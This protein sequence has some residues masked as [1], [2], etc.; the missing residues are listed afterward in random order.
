MLQKGERRQKGDTGST[1]ALYSDCDSR[2]NVAFCKRD[3]V[4]M[5]LR[6]MTMVTGMDL[7]EK[8]VMVHRAMPANLRPGEADHFQRLATCSTPDI[9]VTEYCDAVIAEG[10]EP[11][12]AGQLLPQYFSEEHRFLERDRERFVRRGQRAEA[13]AVALGGE[14]VF[15]CDRFSANY[16]HWLCDALPRLEAFSRRMAEFS[17]L[18]PPPL[19]ALPHV[20]ETLAAW[21][22]VRVV[23]FPKADAAVR[24]EHL[25]VPGHAARNGD[26]APDLMRRVRQRLIAHFAPGVEPSGRRIYVSRALARIR[27]IANESDLQAVLARHGFEIAS[28]EAMPLGEQIALMAQGSALVGI[29]GAGLANML[30]MAPGSRAAEIRQI[31]KVPDCFFSLADALGHEYRY[32]V[33]LPA[34][35]GVHPHA[36]DLVSDPGELDRLLAQM[37]GQSS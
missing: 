21:P 13:N 10:G 33:A 16:Y 30:F 1:A 17:L 3:F 32:L 2:R 26:H 6:P 12:S 9:V 11:F 28:F 29:H 25:L 5:A 20:R 4:E 19:A 22:G 18:L 37:E 36:A 7:L 27:R 31:D 34:N 15:I 23:P 8:G 35:A 14:H 24:V